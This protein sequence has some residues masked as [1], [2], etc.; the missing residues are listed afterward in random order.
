MTFRLRLEEMLMEVF[1]CIHCPVFKS[2]HDCRLRV[3]CPPMNGHV[4]PLDYDKLKVSSTT[5]LHTELKGR[6]D[7]PLL[8]R[9]KK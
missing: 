6:D 8:M 1:L 4:H 3:S 7:L 5:G 2:K 9:G